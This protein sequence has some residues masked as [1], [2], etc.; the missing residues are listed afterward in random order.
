MPVAPIW[1]TTTIPLPGA[2]RDRSGQLRK[3]GMPA[4]VAAL[5]AGL[6]ALAVVL[7]LKIGMTVKAAYAEALDDLRA[8]HS[9]FQGGV[10]LHAIDAA[11]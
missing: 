9:D 2:D 3:R 4:A 10:T 5:R 11:E 6:P 8:L 7:Y 1:R